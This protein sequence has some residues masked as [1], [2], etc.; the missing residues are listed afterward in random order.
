MNGEVSQN[1][2]RGIL[3]MQL[4]VQ[5]HS[6][7]KHGLPRQVEL[8]YSEPGLTAAAWN[9][10]LLEPKIAAMG[11]VQRGAICISPESL[12]TT[13]SAYDSSAMASSRSVTPQKVAAWLVTEGDDFV[14]DFLVFG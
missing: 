2:F 12:L 11:P 13:S 7:L 1:F 14:G 10:G 9:C 4:N 5:R 8:E 3:I 6:R